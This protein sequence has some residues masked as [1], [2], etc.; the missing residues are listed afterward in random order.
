MISELRQKRDLVLKRF[1]KP[2]IYEDIA[3]MLKNYTIMFMYFGGSIAYD[4]YDESISDTDINVFADGFEGYIHTSCADFDLFI[5]GKDYMMKRQK[6][7]PSM[8]EYNRLFIDD[9]CRIDDTLIYLNPGYQK[10][11]DEFVG[12]DIT[13]SLPRY[14]ETVYS[15]FMFLY[16]DS[17]VPL[18]RFYHVIRIRGQLKSYKETGKYDT[19]IPDSYKAE[20]LNFKKNYSGAV[21]REIYRNKIGGYLAEIKALSEG[22]ENDGN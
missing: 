8:S 5:Y 20:M 21:G 11:Y 7:D 4:S 15:Y 17:E 14:L 3:N 1:S 19:T 9:K 2:Q 12:Y 18:K 10:E 6:A 13:A 16:I 22:L